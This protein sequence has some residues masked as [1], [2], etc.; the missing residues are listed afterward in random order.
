MANRQSRRA[1]QRKREILAGASR[2][3]HRRGLHATGMREIAAE[4]GMQVGNLYYYFHNKQELLAFCQD[5]T[6]SGLLRLAEKVEGS[7]LPTDEKLRRLIVGQVEQL[8]ETT[9]GS[10]AH[11]EIEALDE[12]FRQPIQRRRDQYERVYRRI[13]EEG[14]SSG[15]F[16]RLDPKIATRAILG[17]VN[18][19]VKWFR[20]GGKQ[21]ATE[22]GEEL[23]T[24]FIR[25][26]E[27]GD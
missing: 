19:T 14:A 26:L 18:W 1:A 16:R 15:Q 4:L 7:E 6:L 12:E 11:L 22:I 10:L 20:P 25:G 21:T 13:L 3:F 17:A 5:E 24:V 9:P 2:A 23:A 27:R 8:N